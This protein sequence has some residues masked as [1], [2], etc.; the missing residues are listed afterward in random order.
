M[1]ATLINIGDELLIGQVVNTNASWMAEKLNDVNVEVERIVTVADNPREITDALENELHFADVVILTGGLGPTKDDMTKQVLCR[2]F[3]AKMVV[4]QPTLEHV[5]HYFEMRGLPFSELNHHQADVPD[6][7]TVLF[8]EV[9]TAPGMWFEKSGKII[10]SLPGVPSEMMFLMTKYVLPQLEARHADVVILHHTILTQ[11]IGE[12][13]LADLIA[14]WE[15]HLPDGFKLAYLPQ[16]GLVRLRLTARGT[17]K[18]N[19]HKKMA[20]ELE[21][22]SDLIQPYFVGESNDTLELIINKLFTKNCLTLAV[23][24]SCSGGALA[25]KI[26]SVA[27]SSAYFKGGLVAYSNEIKESMLGVSKET[28]AQFGAVSQQTAE[29][30]AKGCRERFGVDYAIAT[31]GIAGPTGGSDEKPVGTVWIGMAS[32]S[33]VTAQKYQL[34]NDRPKVIERTVNQSLGD[35]IKILNRDGKNNV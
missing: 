6:C 1:K 12:S 23:A 16:A 11:G 8:N 17:E 33:G 3:D 13:F 22:L 20:D 31:T 14:D 24:E 29:A 34:G 10:V 25:A 7:C 5:K 4:H 18:M 27:G 15:N 26:V 21:K 19:L 9:G 30:M 2:F 35:L 32:P 28:L